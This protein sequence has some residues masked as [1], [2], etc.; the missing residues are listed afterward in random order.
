MGRPKGS[1]NKPKLA[2]LPTKVEVP[3]VV[4]QIKR[5]R[6]PK[7]EQTGKV[8]VTEVTNCPA[9]IDLDK[10]PDHGFYPLTMSNFLF[11]EHRL[12]KLA[13]FAVSKFTVSQNTELR[14]KARK[15]NIDFRIYLIRTMLLA[16][17]L[18]K[19]QLD[20]VEKE[21]AEYKENNKPT[22]LYLKYKKR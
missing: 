3:L 6:R 7:I 10:G 20:E 4:A 15:V 18:N 2:P 22:Q 21:I 14:S 16:V 17:G 11:N 5:T 8:V 1:K 12:L 13:D 9:E 19:E